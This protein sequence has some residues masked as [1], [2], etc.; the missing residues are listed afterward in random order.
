MGSSC[1]LPVAASQPVWITHRQAKGW[2]SQA[3]FCWHYWKVKWSKVLLPCTLKT[4]SHRHSP[5][6]R[7]CVYERQ[8]VSVTDSLC[9]SQPV[10]VCHRQS[11]SLSQT[12]W[13]CH[14]QAVSN[15]LPEYS[16]RKNG[17]HRTRWALSWDFPWTNCWLQNHGSWS[18]ICFS[19]LGLPLENH[20]WARDARYAPWLLCDSIVTKSYPKSTPWP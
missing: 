16:L 9:L 19:A 11:V 6:Q 4:D 13:S 15:T 20:L 8:S 18:P 7:I 5:E 17:S 10:S 14:R 3:R 1:S 12:V 2:K